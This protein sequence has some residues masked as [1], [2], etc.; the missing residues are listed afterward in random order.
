MVTPTYIVKLHLYRIVP[1]T[2]PNTDRKPFTAWQFNDN[3][4]DSCVAYVGVYGKLQVRRA[5]GMANFRC[6]VS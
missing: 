5:I 6:G 1:N 3:C 4:V 2:I